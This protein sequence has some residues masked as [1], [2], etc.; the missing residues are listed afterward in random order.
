[1]P[2]IPP[3][4]NKHTHPER[5]GGG[6]RGVRERERERPERTKLRDHRER[7]KERGGSFQTD[8]DMHL[9]DALTVEEQNKTQKRGPRTT[10]YADARPLVRKKKR[11]KKEGTSDHQLCRR[12]YSG[13]SGT[14][15]PR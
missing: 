10:N 7:G 3:S 2:H 14:V 9:R 5:E 8:L 12:S 13:E 1:M 4:A 11:H 15:N 6:D